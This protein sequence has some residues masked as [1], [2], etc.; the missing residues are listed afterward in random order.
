MKLRPLILIATICLLP[1]GALAWTTLHE[2]QGEQ[3]VVR[4]QFQ[5]LFETRL[6]D[7]KADVAS[8]FD[9]LERQLDP[10]VALD[11]FETE[12]LRRISRNSPQILQLFVVSPQGELIYPNPA[13]PLN[14][15]EQTFLIKGAQMFTGK[16]LQ[17][18]VLRAEQETMQNVAGNAGS[19][20][21]VP[22]QIPFAPRKNLSATQQRER[23]DETVRNV[24]QTTKVDGLAPAEGRSGW[25]IWY[26]DRGVNLIYWQRRPSGH[27]VG[28]A[29]DRARW[30]SEV[31]AILPTTADGIASPSK[32]RGPPLIAN[33]VRLLNASAEVVYQW[34]Q[35]DAFTDVKPFCEITLAEP[36]EPWR[37][38]CFVSTTQLLQGTGA[39][40]R[41]GA[42]LGLLGLATI[43][44]SILW[45]F[46]REYA[47]D[48]REAAQ[49]VSFVNQVSHELRTPLTNISMYAELLERDIASET[50]PQ[51]AALQ[52]RLNI[53]LSESQRLG[54]LIA[55]VLTFARSRSKV[56]TLQPHLVAADEV[57]Q[58][59]VERARPMLES[60]GVRVQTQCGASLP[61][62]LDSDV[63]AQI[64]ENLLS[65]VEKYASQG[66]YVCVTTDLKDEVLSID[67][68]DR[69][70][71][72][73]PEQREAI[74]RPFVRISSDISHAAGTGIGLTIA[75]ELARLH[76]GDL[77]LIDST[78]G[79]HFRATLKSGS[80]V[81]H[82]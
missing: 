75:R 82:P 81:E 16:D 65:N 52:Q 54:R 47:R 37:L 68:A 76:G 40:A 35:M 80:T 43:M 36:L 77:Q 78:V 22:S 42:L 26:W 17:S 58:A 28:C 11:D 2:A 71:G 6:Q 4:Q 8:Y 62:H 34:G 25:F 21:Q 74:F 61:M 7:I 44:G 73:K 13:G 19:F 27:I 59:V 38:Q 45:L 33:H 5:E 56:L 50:H 18:A 46:F 29:L 67:V 15:T 14:A 9:S 32:L 66:G 30:I 23:V 79:C 63:L 12:S 39:A 41:R 20:E 64:L 49:Q 31:I 57:V 55:N 48:M 3:L 1:L 70:P 51:A 10:V 24:Y 69:G 60:C 72:V 53:I